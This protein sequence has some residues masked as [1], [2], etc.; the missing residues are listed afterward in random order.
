MKVRKDIVRGDETVP[1]IAEH[2]EGDRWRVRVG[3]NVLELGAH[4]LPGGGVRLVQENGDDRQ[5][6]TVHGVAAG[7]DLIVRLDGR[8]HKLSPPAGRG[9]GGSAGG[10]GMILAPMTGTV[11]KVEC[12]PGDTVAA[13][14]TLIVLSAMKMEHKLTAGVAGTVQSVDTE[15][16]GTVEQ[17]AI[18]VVVEPEAQ[19]G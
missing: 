14:Q 11:L 17:G 18:L 7:Q 1:V 10:D 12:Q 6:R 19:N 16:G 2:V 13:D 3:E 4:A 5:V 9:P 15:V 8:T